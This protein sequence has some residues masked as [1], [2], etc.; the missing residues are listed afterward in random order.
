[1]AVNEQAIGNGKP[2]VVIGKVLK[3]FQDLARAN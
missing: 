2:G 1:M 3:A